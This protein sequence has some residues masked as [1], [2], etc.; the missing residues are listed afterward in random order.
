MQEQVWRRAFFRNRWRA[1]ASLSQKIVGWAPATLVI[2]PL[3]SPA[4]SFSLLDTLPHTTRHLPFDDDNDDNM[5]AI[6]QTFQRCK[7][8]NKVGFT[9]PA[10]IAPPRLHR[11]VVRR[12]VAHSTRCEG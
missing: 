7:A 1:S 9:H 11:G 4:S 8:Q 2:K 3:P 6:K 10:A 5:E 12:A